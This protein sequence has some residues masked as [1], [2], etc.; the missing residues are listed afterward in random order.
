MQID[1]IQPISIIPVAR[2]D[3]EILNY[4]LIFVLIQE[5]ENG[6][7]YNTYL[8]TKVL[9]DTLDELIEQLLQ[10]IDGLT[11]LYPE[12][13]STKLI[14]SKDEDTV[15]VVDLQEYTKKYKEKMQQLLMM[16][17][18]VPLILQESIH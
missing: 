9:C 4:S 13:V 7:R 1:F 12:S 11:V 15:E 14:Y 17:A 5:D 2:Y 3:A 10:S 16:E 8:D 6:E 18:N